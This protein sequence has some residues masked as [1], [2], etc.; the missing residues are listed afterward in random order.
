MPW[1]SS[2][3]ITDGGAQ[4]ADG[5]AL[6][7]APGDDS[8]TDYGKP[9]FAAVNGG[10]LTTTGK[11]R[12]FSTGASSSGASVT[13]DGSRIALR[14]TEIRTRGFLATGIDARLGGSAIAENISID[15]DGKMRTASISTSAA[16]ASTSPAAPSSRA[17]A[18]RTASR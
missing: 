5:V 6:E 13:G 18:K 1:P 10:V 8:T 3:Q 4:R 16:A 9:V 7:T 12:L 2:A 15:T 14:D 17:A 11:T